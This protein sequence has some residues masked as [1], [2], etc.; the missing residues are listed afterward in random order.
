M[1]TKGYRELDANKTHYIAAD[2]SWTNFVTFSRLKE[3][4]KSH[5]LILMIFDNGNHYRKKLVSEIIFIK[6]EDSN[7]NQQTIKQT[8]STIYKKFIYNSHQSS[9]I[10]WPVD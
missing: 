8:M 4:T 1:Y 7:M 10:N 6:I 5:C 9:P 2:V 3:Y